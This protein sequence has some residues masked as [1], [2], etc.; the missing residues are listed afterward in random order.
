[1][2]WCMLAEFIK[3]WEKGVMSSCASSILK[4]QCGE[5]KKRRHVCPEHPHKVHEENENDDND[6]KKGVRK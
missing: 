2:Y 5:N 3:T 6:G 1:M 4:T